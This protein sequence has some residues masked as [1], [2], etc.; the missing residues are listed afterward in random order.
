MMLDIDPIIPNSV[1]FPE[2]LR[3][4]A[5]DCGDLSFPPVERTQFD[6]DFVQKNG[7]HILIECSLI[8]VAKYTMDSVT[9]SYA[10]VLEDITK[11]NTLIGQLNLE[12]NHLRL[13]TAQLVDGPA[14]SSFLND[15]PFQSIMVS[16]LAVAWCLID[17]MSD[18]PKPDDMAMIQ[19]AVRKTLERYPKLFF[20]GRSIQI[21]RVVS[22]LSSET[23]TATEISTEIVKF[24]HDLLDELDNLDRMGVHAEM[25]CGIHISGPF[26]GEIV[27]EMPPVFELFGV[28]MPISLEMACSASSNHILISR[29]VYETIFDQGFVISFDKE[30]ALIN[31]DSMALHTVEVPKNPME[32]D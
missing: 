20:F 2:F 14:L 26:Y 25:K 18:R 19:L 12:A 22:G 13:L 5:E 11:L 9:V 32:M 17:D 6:F 1:D 15:T 4:I 7:A 31:G 28:A 21:F 27:S 16:K 10:C 24:T 30:I 8:P 23:M 29:D 3:G